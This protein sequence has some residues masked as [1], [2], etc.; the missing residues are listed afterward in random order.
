MVNG[1]ML[2]HD[3]I[4]VSSLTDVRSPLELQPIHPISSFQELCNLYSHFFGHTWSKTQDQTYGLPHLA[5]VKS[6]SRS[7]IASSRLLLIWSL[8]FESGRMCL[9]KR[10]TGQGEHSLSFS[11]QARVG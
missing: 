3:C 6:L 7:H 1:A 10:T 4:T 5:A 8:T 9:E 11:F 2:L